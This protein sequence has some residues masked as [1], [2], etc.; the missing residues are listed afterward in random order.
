MISNQ[1][2]KRIDT[3]VPRN[4]DLVQLTGIR[5]WRCVAGNKSVELEDNRRHATKSEGS[6]DL[7]Q[8]TILVL[9]GRVGFIHAGA[10][11]ERSQEMGSSSASSR[12]L[13]EQTAM[14]SGIVI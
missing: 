2:L 9:L 5:M 4:R 1:N 13:I 7:E 11:K 12:I 8:A 10:A 14:T 3:A 6:V